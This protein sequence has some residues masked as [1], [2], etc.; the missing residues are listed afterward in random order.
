MFEALFRIV[1]QIETDKQGQQA[2]QVTKDR[3]PV[4]E[5]ELGSLLESI[6]QEQVYPTLR[7]DDTLTFHVDHP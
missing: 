5:T 3:P 6:Y 1:V 2:F 7:A 4:N